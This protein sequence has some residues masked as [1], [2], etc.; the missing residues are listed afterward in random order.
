MSS[1]Y[2]LINKENKNIWGIY[3]SEIFLEDKINTLK[4]NFPNIQLEIE[5][6]IMN[7]NITK[8]RIINPS[9]EKNKLIIK[10]KK[11]EKKY[12]LNEQN[13]DIKNEVKRIEEFYKLFK[14][15]LKSY[16]NIKEN[17]LEI[18]DFFK[19]KFNV[20]QNIYDNNIPDNEQFSYF[21]SNIYYK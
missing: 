16:T 9:F 1:I 5:E 6:K 18:P 3:N 15:D 12:I 10:N 11:E 19:K 14:E 7:T 13:E 8:K 20:I 2:I 4:E 21:V 17:K